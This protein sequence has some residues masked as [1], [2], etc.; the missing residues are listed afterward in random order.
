MKTMNKTKRLYVILIG[1]TLFALL[2]F[3]SAWLVRYYPQV[4]G[5]THLPSVQKAIRNILSER[6]G[7]MVAM[8]VSAILIA[9]SSLAFQTITGNRILTPAALGFDAIYAVTQTL[10]VTLLGFVS[11]VLTNVYLNFVI[12]TAVMIGIVF[13]MYSLVLRKSKNNIIFL[14]LIGIIISSL[15]GSVS[16]VIQAAMSDDAFFSVQALTNVTITNINRDLVYVLAPIMILISVFLFLPHKT[17]DVMAL[18]EEQATNLGVNYQK[19]S[20][21]TLVLIAL[22]VAVATALVG[23]LSFL[24]LLAVNLAREL[25]KRYEHKHLFLFS[26]FLA[27]IFIFL[28][29]VLVEL[30]GY[31][32]TVTTI[33]SLV[34]GG[35]MIYLLLRK[36]R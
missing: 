28:G 12:S 29:Q 6:S 15:A 18:G 24:G 27:I 32:T 13:L 5:R 11:V 14:L 2:A 30:T 10:M 34:G 36:D 9:F 8:L 20:R 25:S 23:P 7:Q 3:M 22:S 31:Q 16:N 19:Q 17:Y 1:V 33:I 26:A 35:N 21:I 4:I